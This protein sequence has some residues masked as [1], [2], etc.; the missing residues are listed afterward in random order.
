MIGE[1]LTNFKQFSGFQHFSGLAE[2]AWQTD[3]RWLAR[4]CDRDIK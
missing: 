1:I 3:C 2:S 4:R